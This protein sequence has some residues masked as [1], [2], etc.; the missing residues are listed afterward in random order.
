MKQALPS[1][2]VLK[3]LVVDTMFSQKRVNVPA[4]R[5]SLFVTAATHGGSRFTPQQEGAQ[6]SGLPT[7]CRGT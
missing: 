7:M 1:E 4:L 3:V 5:R 6:Y 2:G